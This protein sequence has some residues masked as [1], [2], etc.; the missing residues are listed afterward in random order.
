MPA[1][2]SII[3]LGDDGLAS[4]P[5]PVRRHVEAAELLFG[6]ERAL[7]LTPASYAGER[8]TL[9][10]DLDEL[11]TQLESAGDRPAVMLV[12]GDPMFYGLA[13][14][15]TERLGK[16]RFQ[17][18][19]HVSSM[20]LA[21]ARVMESWDDAYLTSVDSRPL[22]ATIE[23]IRTA[24]KVGLFTSEAIG[25]ADVAR[26]LVDRGIDYFNAYVCENLGSK[27][28]TVTRGTLPEIAGQRFGPLN[29][30]VLVRHADA[31][32]R[33]RSA[34]G[35]RL[36]GNPDDAFL[37]SRPQ[38]G[39]LTTAEVRAQ[40]L[41]QLDIAAG[42][43]VWDIGA[44]SGSVGVEAAQL[45][46]D[47][48]VYAIEMDPSEHALI[49]QNAE[50]FSVA[51]LSAVLG[52]APD[53]WANLPD[54]D[55][56]FVAGAGREVAGIAE[57]AYGRLRPS[58]RL[59]VNV[60]SIDNLAAVRAALRPLCDDVHAWMINVARGA[61]QLDRLTFEPLKPSFLLAAKKV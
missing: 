58:G 32:D 24:S 7:A 33:P 47:G 36:F 10:G 61:E 43:I 16:D 54:P 4:A 38:A 19:P 18:I 28:E 46:A 48:M 23:R 6:N 12:F 22:D 56:V 27:D 55:C 40:A 8:V 42:S 49:E 25:P 21:F 41:A 57:S 11:A 30:L 5:E 26:A 53:A 51:N 2:I 50:R 52:K 9:S 3:G 13:R 44:G 29:V 37:Q 31:P 39:L 17:V 60:L 59:V 1:N 15:V 20:Q 35:F 34:V 14:Y 45:A